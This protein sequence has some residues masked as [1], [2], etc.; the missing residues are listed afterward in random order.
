MGIPSFK[1]L[2]ALEATVRLGTT[3]KAAEAL[4]ISQTA[5]S[6]RLKDLERVL[7][8]SLFTRQGGRLRPTAQAI[9]L[10]DTVRTCI[11][12]LEQSL[13]DI[14][15]NIHEYGL[16][17]SM[18]PALATKWLAPRLAVMAE[19]LQ[20]IKIH[21][22]ASRNLIDLRQEGMDAAIRYGR[23]EWPETAA[24]HLS[25]EY[26]CPV[27]SRELYKELHD[28]NLL[29]QPSDLLQLPLL[30]SDVPDHWEDWFTRAGQPA[31]RPEPVAFFDDD[32]AL[33]EAC[34]A[35]H[36]VCLGRS[37]LVANDLCNGRLVAPFPI[38]ME[39][40]FGYWL[41]RNKASPATEAFA[42]FRQWA[43]NALGEDAKIFHSLA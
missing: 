24:V 25:N 36:G 16:T 34:I 27:V 31:I 22:S 8:T 7:G 30:V 26:L 28:G 6:H 4:S 43:R 15:E 13:A 38:F 10:A 35:G 17:V 3:V 2:L 21:V 42:R 29:Q 41:V 37:V 32:A 12:L 33:I 18:L 23:G 14:D 40:R 39:A 5:V 20:G 1:S 11:G 9:T 19:A